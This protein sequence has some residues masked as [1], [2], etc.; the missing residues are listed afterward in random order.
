MTHMAD[1]PFLAPVS[2]K[3]RRTEDA[4]RAVLKAFSRDPTGV[5][6]G[7]GAV[8]VKRKSKSRAL[9]SFKPQFVG[10]GPGLH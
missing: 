6:A 2:E 3:D 4:C 7:V 5:G 10:C 9:L 1:F 8:Y